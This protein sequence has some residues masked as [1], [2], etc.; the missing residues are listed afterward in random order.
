LTEKH[1]PLSHCAEE[2][3]HSFFSGWFAFYGERIRHAPCADFSVAMFSMTA[4][5]ADF[6]IPVAVHNSFVLRRL[7]RIIA[8][9]FFVVSIV[10]AVAAGPIISFLFTVLKAAGP[11]ST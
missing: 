4:I 5:T 2:V 1:L 10:A 7:S 6:P 9:T 11:A 3:L 8:S